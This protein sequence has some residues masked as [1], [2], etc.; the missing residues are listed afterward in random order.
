V[1]PEEWK[2]FRHVDMA[3]AEGGGERLYRPSPTPPSCGIDIYAGLTGVV[4]FGRWFAINE[5]ITSPIDVTWLPT[6]PECIEFALVGGSEPA[7]LQTLRLPVPPAARA[8]G[9]RLFEHWDAQIDRADREANRREWNYDPR[10]GPVA[11][12]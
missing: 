8:E 7:R 10:R 1:S 11:R 9:R 2:R 5:W 4:I 12:S 3:W 6:S